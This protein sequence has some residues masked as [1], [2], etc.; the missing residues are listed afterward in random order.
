LTSPNKI[1]ILKRFLI[2]GNCVERTKG[3]FSSGEPFQK[4]RKQ[5]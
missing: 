2:M 4:V 5:L 3:L 1:I